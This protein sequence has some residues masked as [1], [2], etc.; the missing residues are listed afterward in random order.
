MG[1]ALPEKTTA[2]FD[3]I[4]HSLPWKGSCERAAPPHGAHSPA[5]AS[6][7]ARGV[8]RAGPLARRRQRPA[9]FAC[10][11][12]RQLLL[13][14]RLCARADQRKLVISSDEII[15]KDPASGSITNRWPKDAF[16]AATAVDEADSSA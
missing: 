1:A 13:L 14:L 2:E 15:T 12:R 6:R 4:K 5:A 9:A 8:T 3:A 11:M 16:R 10:A 7:R